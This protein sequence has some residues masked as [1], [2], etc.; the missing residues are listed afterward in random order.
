MMVLKLQ[1]TEERLQYI[2]EVLELLRSKRGPL[3][4][5]MHRR[6]L[7]KKVGP[8]SGGLELAANI[9]SVI[10]EYIFQ[11]IPGLKE[12][13]PQIGG[14][15]ERS[16]IHK[17]V[18]NW[19]EEIKKPISGEKQKILV[20]V[21]SHIINHIENDIYIK[22]I[23]KTSDKELESLGLDKNLQELLVSLL[24]GGIKADPL[25]IK[26]LSYS[27]KSPPP[28]EGASNVAL[29][30]PDKQW[31][32]IAS[33]FP[34][35]TKS[36][37]RH[38]KNISDNN[39]KWIDIPDGKLFHEYIMTITKMYTETDI[40]EAQKL[41]AKIEELYDATAKSDFPIILTP[42]LEGFYKPPYLDPELR[43]SIASPDAKSQE[44]TF[45]PIQKA[46]AESLN[47]LGV[48]QFSKIIAQKNIRAVV[49]LG[50]YGVCLSFNAVAQEQPAILL[51]LNEQI[52]SY[53]KD[54]PK[55]LRLI[56]GHEEEFQN[57]KLEDLE[58]IS[59]MDTIMHE[60]SHYVYADGTPESMKM[61][62]KPIVT[63]D[64]I[65]AELIYRALI[66]EMLEKGA[67]KGS[68]K[69][70]AMA[71]VSIPLQT[72]NS[73]DPDEYYKAAVYT[74]DEL[75]EKKIATFDGQLVTIHK[76]DEMFKV[77][78]SKA[79][80]IIKLYEDTETTEE[81]AQKWLDDNTI[82]RPA[83]QEVIDFIKTKKNY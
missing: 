16:V 38:L 7:Y 29:Y 47:V 17:I 8:Y 34:R 39:S 67:L 22:V 58:R 76:V 78:K 37:A 14:M 5:T 49:A 36:L 68:L 80:A 25:F 75:F 30:G 50:S 11:K 55:Y 26:F 42:A 9:R 41:H 15:P 43:I 63:V 65:K 48:P 12:L 20:A 2:H 54:F 10:N 28:P 19:L 45:R 66:P 70:W 62:Y 74:L 59:R 24:Q 13:A 3:G 52:A 18:E 57:T 27:Q 82:A 77:F 33:L 4:Q 51:F 83:L 61:G 35:E 32:T 64:E 6:G 21:I 44:R 31:H 53:D 46:M 60:L 72:L 40:L 71:T 23:E 69:Q 73:F 79:K 81:K 1:T 56:K